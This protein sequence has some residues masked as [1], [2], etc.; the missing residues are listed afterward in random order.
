MARKIKS[1][2]ES[3]RMTNITMPQ[4]TDILTLLHE[5]KNSM[6]EL[7]FFIRIAPAIFL[8]INIATYLLVFQNY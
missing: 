7:P 8:I 2:A 4:K 6:K 5:L 1:F 3:Y